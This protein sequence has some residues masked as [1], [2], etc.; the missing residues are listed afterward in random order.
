MFATEFHV[1]CG[2]GLNHPLGTHRA[3]CNQSRVLVGVRLK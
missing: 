3:P 2:W 1:R